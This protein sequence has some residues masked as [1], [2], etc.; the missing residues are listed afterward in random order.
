M[1]PWLLFAVLTAFANSNYQVI[2]SDEE[3][4][5]VTG[6]E[7]TFKC[8]AMTYCF[9]LDEGDTVTFVNMPEFEM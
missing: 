2:S 7:G 1:D 8:Q 9:G 4:I 6:A 5:V 3:T